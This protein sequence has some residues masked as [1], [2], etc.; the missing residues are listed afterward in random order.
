MTDRPAASLPAGS[1]P[2]AEFFLART[3]E[4]RRFR[5]LLRSQVGLSRR[6]KL[7]NKI[8]LMRDDREPDPHPDSPWIFLFHGEGGMGKST[9]IRRLQAI[10][11]GKLRDNHPGD[12][13]W[14]DRFTILKI[15]WENERRNRPSLQGQR[16]QIAES[17][18]LDVL[19]DQ[20]AQVDRS[21]FK[22]YEQR[23]KDLKAASKKVSDKLQTEQQGSNAGVSKALAVVAKAGL[24]WLKLDDVVKDYGDQID[25]A[26]EAATELAPQVKTWLQTQL[27]REELEVFERPDQVL[28]D[29][30]GKGLAKLAARKPLLM[31]LDTYEVVDRPECD[32]VV[33]LVMKAAGGRVSWVVAGRS[34]LRNSGK[35]GEVYF[36]GYGDDFPEAKIYAKALDEFGEAEIRE[37]FARKVPDRPID[38][39]DAQAIREFSL[40]IPFMVAEIV[41]IWRDCPQLSWQQILAPA[42]ADDAKPPR[43]R[44]IAA[45]TERFLFHCLQQ[46]RDEAARTALTQDLAAIYGLA[47]VRR[48]DDRLLLRAMLKQED[49]NPTLA[50]LQA[51]YSFVFADQCRLHDNLLAY[52]RPYL[53]AAAQRESPAVQSL[54][55]RALAH[56]SER[57]TTNQQ[58]W[59]EL[60]DRFESENAKALWLDAAHHHFWKAQDPDR[61]ETAAWKFWLGVFVDAWLV[62]RAFAGEL[63]QVLAGLERCLSAD[64]RRRWGLIQDAWAERR[65]FDCDRRKAWLD[66]LDKLARR[67]WLATDQHPERAATLELER[68]R[69][70]YGQKQ[71]SAALQAL[72]ALDRRWADP[73]P[74]LREAIADL[75]DDFARRFLWPKSDTSPV[76]SPEGLQAAQ[77]ACALQ[78]DRPGYLYNRAVALNGA[79]QHQEAAEVYQQVI[80]LRPSAACYNG[81]GA[82]YRDLKQY[83]EAIAAYQQAITLDPNFV[84]AHNGLGNA[85]LDL[86][87]YEE[88][89]ASCQRA[90]ELDP[91]LATAHS[92]LGAAYLNSQRYDEAIT[93]CQQA[94]ELDPNLAMAHSN[95]G[96]AYAGLQ[97]YD[98]AITSC[99][100]AIEL[101]PNLAMAHSN[102]GAAYA[103]LQR[104]DEA[105][106]SCQR[107]I[108][109]D[110]NLAMAHSNLG[111]AYLN[112]QRYD[113]AI[114]S[115]QRAIELD[116]NLAM[117]H[118]NLGAAY[119]NLQ[120]YNEA[121][122]SC[123]Q[124]IE[125]D[126]NLAQARSNLGGAYLNS[127][128]YDEAVIHCKKA[129]EL[130]QNLAQAHSN[131]GLVL[132]KLQ[133]YPEAEA[134]Y[135]QALSIEESTRDFRNLG[136]A[137]KAQE[138]YNEAIEAYQRGIDLDPQNT[139]PYY[140]LGLLQFEQGDLAGAI[141]TFQ[142]AAELDPNDVN[143]PGN[144]GFLHLVTDRLDEAE[145][146][147]LKARELKPSFYM[148]AFNLAAVRALRSDLDSARSLL[149]ESLQLCPKS[150]DQE[151]LHWAIISILLGNVE[152]GF[153]QLTA[154][155]ATLTDPTATWP[156]RGGVLEA[157][158][159]IARSPLQTPD[160]HRAIERLQS[161]ARGCPTD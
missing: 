92:N 48:P 98:E 69:L 5:E 58:E 80:A 116:P 32:A 161:H 74:S 96:A 28:A 50:N 103:G 53:L 47:I 97:R 127:Q 12:R 136:N 160:L 19:F 55:D 117:A 30:L 10:A 23:L 133:H 83:E 120:R 26:T 9:L 158:Q 146:Y 124:A 64:G 128:R 66:E 63:V 151:Q 95:L 41:S 109:L 61:D 159:A 111:A 67:G 60:G 82:V 37:Y 11:E 99:Q 86:K 126:P 89:I 112:L 149:A 15:D 77:R 22:D 102:L 25:A 150:D 119:L 75:Y 147:L 139:S 84:Y 8:G 31:I 39:A 87:R 107:A 16:D 14:G 56:L 7:L 21:C 36:K 114:T 17:A 42:P 143:L 154:T 2:E 138:R 54:N 62:N 144:L 90:I 35:R 115:C 94:I 135:R 152:A 108:E 148:P 49:L 68:A 132:E 44:A 27:N 88:A 76:S 43:D 100:R 129:I 137:M 134:A 113:E 78:P 24:R 93:S 34:N 4:Q 157:S 131:F 65:N 45:M 125:L 6:R 3:E 18:V 79:K 1:A 20:A 57:L 33:R 140:D 29:A 72:E 118:S 105:I 38:D 101:D 130:D 71:D 106:T 52:L 142:K 104:Y 46:G 51:R 153:E 156:I 123:Q 59:P 121:I 91:N 13:A 145:T 81:L 141:A 155:L 85:Y 70:L 40:G 122:A 110:P 73:S